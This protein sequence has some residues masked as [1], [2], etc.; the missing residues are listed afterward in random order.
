M[1][2]WGWDWVP[3]SFRERNHKRTRGKE[4]KLATYV[5]YLNFGDVLRGI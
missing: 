4:D 5:H 3:E 2:A 1:F